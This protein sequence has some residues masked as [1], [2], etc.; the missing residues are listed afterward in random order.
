MLKGSKK[1]EWTNKC[2]QAF[3]ALKEHLGCPLLLSKPIEGEKLYLYLDVFEEA[4][5]TALVR[6]EEKVQWPVYYMSKRLLDAETRY[7]DL[8]K[9]ALALMVASRKL[10]P[11]FHA[12]PIE[13]LTNYPLRQVLQ[14][15]EALGRLLKWAIKLGQFDVNFLPRTVIKGQALVNF[16]VD[17]PTPMLL[18]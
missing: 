9:L 14:K 16:I 7:L 18:K 2:E 15:L 6:G 17:S 8:E 10:R 4:V 11:Y 13:V 12:H 1:F 3:L 5:R